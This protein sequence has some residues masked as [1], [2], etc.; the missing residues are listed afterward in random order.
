MSSTGT[1]R[2]GRFLL[3][4]GALA[5]GLMAPAIFAQDEKKED[6]EE[7]KAPVKYKRIVNL[8]NINDKDR[9]AVELINKHIEEGWRENEL[10]PSRPATDFEFIR[11]ATLDIVGRIATV[12]EIRQYAR[13]PKDKRRQMLI[14][15]LL[16]SPDYPRH[17]AN[18]WANWLLSRAGV[19]GRGMYH[20]Q[21]ATWLEDQFAQSTRWDKI[22]TELLTASGRNSDNGAVN[23]ILAH[24]GEPIPN[25]KQREDG[26]F[27]MV[28]ITARITRLFLGIQTQCTQCHDHPFDANLRQEHFWGINAFLRQVTRQGNLPRR[29][30]D[31][32]M[33]L[34]LA[35]QSQNNR[36]AIVRYEK[37]NGVLLETKARF[38]DGTKLPK[39]S[40]GDRRAELAKLIV[41]HKNF[42]KAI[43]NRMWA[44]FIGVGFVNPIDDF[45]ELNEPSHPELL[46]ELGALFKHYEYDLK[47]LIRWICNSEAYQLSC[48]AN[49]TND[50]QE[51]EVF[52]ARVKLKSMTPEQ[53]FESL[54][55][56]TQSE[57]TKEARKELRDRWLNNLVANFGD[58][59]GNE[60]TF[61][62][63][64]VQALLM[65]NGND[66]NSAISKKDGGT[67][68]SAMKKYNRPDQRINY[69][70]LAALNRPVGATEYR[71][72]LQKIKLRPGFSDK[73]QEAPYQDLFWALLNSNEFILNH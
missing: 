2:S 40:T 55:V 60:I 10:T 9:E 56:A 33:P 8:K 3:L 31:A 32:L 49:S 27:E 42:P 61:N 69:L 73:T 25:N 58:D 28:P 68:S 59:E 43:I 64:V 70:Y 11:R 50:K 66:I 24:V 72:I 57:Q 21:M 29:Q 7:K 17:W 54:M 52:F 47:K 38:L 44:N 53:L 19:F 71:R 37:R 15:K 63:T 23:F 18:L 62:G 12:E 14:E 1:M 41:G 51:H 36:N 34:T 6:K 67:L 13:W 30:R 4:A 48:V 45:N 46:D 35:V 20:E 39:G 65:M 16:K 26:Q 22:V 5:I